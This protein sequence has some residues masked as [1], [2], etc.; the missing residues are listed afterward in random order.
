MSEVE[1]RPLEGHVGGDGKDSEV[2]P[3]TG[4][5]KGFVRKRLRKR[6]SN[7]DYGRYKFHGSE[8]HWVRSDCVTEGDTR[9]GPV[10]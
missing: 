8:R 6:S 1:E 5:S 10:R 4:E 7:R 9:E 2:G 3:R